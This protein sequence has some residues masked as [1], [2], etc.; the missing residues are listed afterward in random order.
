MVVDTLVS[1]AFK[2]LQNAYVRLLQN[3]FY[4]PDEHT[5][6]TPNGEFKGAGT[7]ITSR[8]FVDEVRRIGEAWAPG[9]S[10]L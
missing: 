8:R 4:D 2:A 3:P 6:V 5:P 7:Q 1:K 10:S 9:V